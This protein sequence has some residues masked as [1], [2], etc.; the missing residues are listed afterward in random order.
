MYNNTCDRASITCTYRYQP[1]TVDYLDKICHKINENGIYEELGV[2]LARDS[3]PYQIAEFERLI[4]QMN[5][6]FF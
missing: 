3:R 4:R 6:R 5:T 2:S 1:I